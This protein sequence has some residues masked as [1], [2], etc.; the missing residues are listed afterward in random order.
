LVEA[1]GKGRGEGMGGDGR[2]GKQ[3]EGGGERKG[4]VECES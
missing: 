3:I 4:E 1:R 2:S